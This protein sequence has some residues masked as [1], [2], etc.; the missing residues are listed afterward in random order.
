[1]YLHAVDACVFPLNAGV[2]LNRSSLGAA[3]TDGLPL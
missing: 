2:T 3:A 1:M